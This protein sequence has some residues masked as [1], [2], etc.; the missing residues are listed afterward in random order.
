MTRCVVD[1]S[2]ALA[3]AFQEPGSEG[4]RRVAESHG[5][6]A[7]DLMLVEVGNVLWAKVRR[8]VVE[9]AVA[10]RLFDAIAAV[11]VDLAPMRALMPSARALAFTLDETVHD[12][13][14]LALALRDGCM[15]AT[16]D[17]VFADRIDAAGLLPGRL[18]LV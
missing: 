2:V 8:R 5:L 16:A 10:D 12:C 9:R 11:P 6:L 18:M 4:A 15:L 1:A 3:W 13:I 7:P 17:R 14:Y